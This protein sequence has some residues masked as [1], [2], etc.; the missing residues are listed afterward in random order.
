[1]A[2]AGVA[3]GVDK[4][5]QGRVVISALQVIE[6]RLRIVVVAVGAKM[7]SIG[8]FKSSIKKAEK[9]QKTGSSPGRAEALPGHEFSRSRRR[10]SK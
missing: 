8:L 9:W 4:S 7:G 5:S 1:M 10:G 6:A 2:G 3:V